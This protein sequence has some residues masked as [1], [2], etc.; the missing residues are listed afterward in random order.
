M[1]ALR[2]GSLTLLAILAFVLAGLWVLAALGQTVALLVAASQAGPEMA[3]IPRGVIAIDAAWSA[4]G[5][6][7]LILGGIGL[8]RLSAALGRWPLTAWALLHAA[9]SIGAPL[10]V[11]ALRAQAHEVGI[12]LIM[13]VLT[14]VWLHGVCRDVWRPPIL[15]AGSAGAD[16]ALVRVR[17][18]WI[19]TGQAL[20]QWLRSAG[21]LGFLVAW[22]FVA[23]SVATG[24]IAVSDRAREAAAKA[25]LS[26]PGR[27]GIEGAVHWAAARLTGDDAARNASL[28]AGVGTATG[29]AAVWTRHLVVDHP[30]ETSFTWLLLSLCVALLAP[31]AASGAI[32]R[33][34]GNRGFRFLLVRIGRR[35]VF[36][37]RALAPALAVV[38][39]CGLM[40][41]LATLGFALARPEWPL[42]TLLPWSAWA[43]VALAVSALPYVALALLASTV[44]GHGFGALAAVKGA[45]ALIP[46]VAFA[47]AALWPPLIHTIHLLPLAPQLFLFH[48][49]PWVVA[50]AAAACLLYAGLVARLALAH[51]E[52][53]DL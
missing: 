26:E 27:S 15:A 28:L 4:A 23:G 52:R 42:A 17:P 38:A 9:W 29:P 43:A 12:S 24:V 22:L 33:D 37:G 21:G 53:R 40:V 45:I 10:A 41:G 11:P 8:L 5:A 2:P 25:G 32:A 30:A 36:W 34:I 51:F 31:F 18:V 6:G 14:L 20:R 48:H 19:S 44:V 1:R 46:A 3:G 49:Q 13:P 7:L 16:A 35:E 47:L 50:L 39:A